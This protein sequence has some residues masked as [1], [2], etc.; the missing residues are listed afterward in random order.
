MADQHE[1]VAK[2]STPPSQRIEL[3][4][5]F[6]Q[7]L[8]VWYPKDY[9]VAAIDAADGPAAVE[10][11]L[12]AGFGSNAAHLH[13]SAR[14]CQ[15]GAAIYEQRTPMQRA[16]AAFSRAVTDEG[17][18]AQEYFEEAK[19]GA[20]LIAVRASEPPLADEARRILAAHGARRMRFY[21]DRT[22]TDLS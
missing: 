13:N 16:G 17:L 12:A 18:M 3:S 10:A 8:G 14:V 6:A 20:S 5:L 21:G 9:V 11:L 1:K 7:M 2:T 19:A 15:I 22:I 4:G